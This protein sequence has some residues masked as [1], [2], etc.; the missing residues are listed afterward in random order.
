ML[1]GTLLVAQ[2]QVVVDKS[3]IDACLD[4]RFDG[5][6]G[7]VHR[8]GTG[9]RAAEPQP[10]LAAEQP[11]PARAGRNASGPRHATL[12]AQPRAAPAAA[13]PAAQR[14]DSSWKFP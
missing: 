9:L 11:R 13:D 6:V 4:S 10:T 14:H 2:A 8:S 1:Q 12:R 5:T 3:E 7:V